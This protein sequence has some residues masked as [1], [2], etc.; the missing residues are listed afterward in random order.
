MKLGALQDEKFYERVKPMLLWKTTEG[1]WVT[2]EEHLERTNEQTHGKI[3]YTTDEAHAAPVLQ[4]YRDKGVDLLI[5]DSNIDPYLIRFLEEKVST[6][7]F[8]R[9]D[10]AVD[11]FL[12]DPT[13]ENIVL[14]ADGKSE[15]AHLVDL[16]KRKLGDP[17]VEVEAKSLA[18][19]NL[20]GFVTMEEH[21]RRLR[22]YMR[23]AN[24]NES[25]MPDKMF[26]KR[27]FIINT[28]H[29]LFASLIKLD[30]IDPEL[31]ESAVKYVYELSLLSQREL[32]PDQMN[33]FIQ[34]GQEVLHR[35]TERA[36]QS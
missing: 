4:L 9:I 16:V 11:E 21:T 14:D 18:T 34:R 25:G 29:P 28:N 20:P 5:A 1:N 35:L 36:V 22:D 10:S 30:A 26:G 15:A 13:K 33:G 32:S 24:P 17:E 23:M 6:A 3:L 19:N 8:Q 27:T 31:T 12:L 7:K 2:V